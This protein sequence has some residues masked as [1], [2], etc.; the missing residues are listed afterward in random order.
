MASLSFE[1][2]KKR[3]FRFMMLGRMFGTMALQAQAVIVGWQVYV[4]TG[5]EFMLGLTGLAEAVPALVCGLFA[6][7]VVDISRPLRVLQLCVGVLVLNILTLFLIAG[8]IVPLA[9][10]HTVA[11]IFLAVFISGV[12]RSFMMPSSFSLLP[13]IIPRHNIPAANAWLTASFQAGF[14]IGPAMAGLIY[15]GYGVRVAWLWPLILIVMQ[16]LFV[17][18]LGKEHRDFRNSEVRESAVKSIKAGWRFIFGNRVLLAAMSIDMLVVLFGGVMAILPAFADKV[19]ALGSEGLGLLRAA[20]AIGAGGM[21]LYFALFPP[22]AIHAKWLL[23]VMGGFGLSMIGFGLSPWLWMALCFLVLSGMF[24]AVGMVVR[25]TLTQWLT[26]AAMRGRVS[27]V[28]SMFVI[29]SNELG[30]FFS[31]SMATLMGLVPSILFGGGLSLAVVAV[32]AK[33]SP[34][35]RHTVIDGSEDEKKPTA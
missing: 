3:D 23:W 24:D 19:L 22:K 2:L 4:L 28:N 17:L 35:L 16:M 29:S 31:G 25:Q 10:D 11:L 9:T 27:S 30:A 12:A 34:Q 13:Q 5:S 15:G 14:I 26:P 20:P 21:T 8:G 18:A 33:W 32:I 6:G 1:V 7:Y